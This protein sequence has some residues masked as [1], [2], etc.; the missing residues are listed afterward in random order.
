MWGLSRRCLVPGSIDVTLTVQSQNNI[1][2]DED[3]HLAMSGLLWQVDST[4]KQH[5]GIEHLAVKDTFFR[6]VLTLAA[7]KIAA[8]FSRSGGSCVRISRRLVVKTGPFVHLT[9][10][11]TLSF[12]ASKTS[13]PV[14]RV[15][16]A[17][18][19]NNRAF[20]V[21]DRIR[22]VSLTRAWTTLSDSDRTAIYEQLK[23]MFQELRSLTPPP[24]VG[25]ESCVG[26]S[27][28]DSRIARSSP[29]FGPFKTTQEFHLWLRNGLRPEDHP[30]REE[31]ED[32]KDIKAMAQKQDGPWPAPVFTHGDLNPSNI[33]VHGD[34]VV[35]IIDWEFAG[36]YPYYWEYTSAWQAHL[37]RQ[38]WEDAILKFLDPYPQELEMEITRQRW[39]GA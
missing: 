16:C 23:V 5:D 11:S 13:I 34:R 21:M 35:G 17:F 31:D 4:A 37:T 24:G 12:V 1:Q 10:A 20:I 2:H 7:F 9:E 36:W 22:G 26:G 6:R 25:V 38:G 14:P 3:N 28:R 15:H 39:W 29:R 8:R 32:W 18:V 33:L 27:L 30:D 19:H